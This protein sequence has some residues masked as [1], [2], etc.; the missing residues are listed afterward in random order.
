ML[1][2]IAQPSTQPL[3]VEFAGTAQQ[4][5]AEAGIVGCDPAHRIGRKQVEQVCMLCPCWGRLFLEACPHQVPANGKGRYVGRVMLRYWRT[6]VAVW[7]ELDNSTD[8]QPLPCRRARTS[9]SEDSQ[10]NF[11]RRMQPWQVS[12]VFLRWGIAISSSSAAPPGIIQLG[13]AVRLKM[14]GSRPISPVAD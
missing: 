2:N 8:P 4:I 1:R 11:V 7:R 12:N 9:A 13:G 14:A 5:A 10:I 6:E 3:T